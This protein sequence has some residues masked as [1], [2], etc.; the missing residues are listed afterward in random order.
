MGP[1]GGADLRFSSPQPDT[2]LYCDPGHGVSAPRG[3]SVY[4]PA[5][6]GTHLLTPEAWMGE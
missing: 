1:L 5:E 2:S 6:A 3:M 4:F